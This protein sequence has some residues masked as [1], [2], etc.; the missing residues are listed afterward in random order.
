MLM[1][2]YPS[3]EYNNEYMD[4]ISDYYVDVETESSVSISEKISNFKKQHNLS[5]DKLSVI[6]GVDSSL[7]E[8]IEDRKVYPS[9][10]IIHQISRALGHAS[11]DLLEKGVDW[12]F[13]VIRSDEVKERKNARLD[14]DHV[15]EEIKKSGMPHAIPVKAYLITLE[16]KYKKND[17]SSHAGEEFVKVDKG[18]VK[19]TLHD[20]EV[21]LKEGDSVY[22][23]S[24]IPHK[25]ENLASKESKITV[26][27]YMD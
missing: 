14:T 24:V 17:F 25:I 21:I 12:G 13:T 27:I 4:F 11:Q 22:F 2:F 23:L 3:S 20:R 7:L 1:A 18:E 26:I 9:L 5:M 6:T 8:R 16:G 10:K 19:V 15:L